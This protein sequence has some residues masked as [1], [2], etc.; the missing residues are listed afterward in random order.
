MKPAP[1]V[2]GLSSK[3]AS[4]RLRIDGFNELPAPDRR[5]RLRIALEVLRQPMF[6][7]LIGAGMVYLFLGDRVEAILLLVFAS[8]S[9]A[10][11]IVQ[12]SRSEHVLE[13]LRNLSSPEHWS[14]RTASEFMLR[15][16]IWYA[17]T[18]S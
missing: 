14:F 9:V 1:A 12:E 17:R 15:A 18:L 8:L 13:T 16:E 5:D 4:E 10:I 6:A 2:K 11:T 3:L 7:L